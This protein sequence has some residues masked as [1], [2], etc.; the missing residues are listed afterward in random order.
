M[1]IFDTG[2][3]VAILGTETRSGDFE[4]AD[5]L[6]AGV[7]D[8]ETSIKEK[9]KRE[10]AMEVDEIASSNGW[11]ALVSGLELESSI[12][13]VTVNKGSNVKENGNG[14]HGMMGYAD[15]E[16]KL[17]LLTEWLLGHV[18]GEEVSEKKEVQ[19]GGSIGPVLL[20]LELLSFLP[21]KIKGK[22]RNFPH[23]ES[24]HSWEFHAKCLARRGRQSNFHQ[25]FYTCSC[26]F[27]SN[28]QFR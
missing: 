24:S 19:I 26:T 6:F 15:K 22:K 13:S 21:P 2:V 27:L 23:Y 25:A 11:V 16:L 9:V 4:I 17:M 5:A 1:L 14:Q 3:V 18:G 12:A 28:V 10:D 20:N 8:K 7:P